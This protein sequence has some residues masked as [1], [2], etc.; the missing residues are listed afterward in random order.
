MENSAKNCRA[1][2]SFVSV[3]SDHRIVIARIRLTLQANKNKTSKIKPH[4][5]IYLKDNAEII[6]NVITEVNNQFQALQNYSE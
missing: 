6:N 2:N 3:S 1:F 4:D 5:W